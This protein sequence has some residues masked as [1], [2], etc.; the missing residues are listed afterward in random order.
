MK[1]NRLNVYHNLA[2]LPEKYRTIFESGDIPQDATS[3]F[4][5]FRHNIGQFSLIMVLVGLPIFGI[6]PLALLYG[7]AGVVLTPDTAA[8]L[9]QELTAPDDLLLWLLRVGVVLI[10]TVLPLLML[11]I[12]YRMGRRWLLSWQATQQAATG[13]HHYGLL[14]DGENLV[15]RQ[16][17]VLGNFEIALL[18]KQHITSIEEQPRRHNARAI[19]D[20]LIHYEDATKQPQTLALGPQDFQL[21]VNL[22]LVQIL[23][24]WQRQA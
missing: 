14:L 8:A 2:T 9:W 23:K 7:M 6:L 20:C 3:R 13:E 5:P 10:N 19:R 4:Y 12:L 21:P 17:K 15:C 24:Q 16:N 11:G 18:P 1:D 22:S